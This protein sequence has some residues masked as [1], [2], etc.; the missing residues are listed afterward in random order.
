M[1]DGV[2][3]VLVIGTTPDMGRVIARAGWRRCK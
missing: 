3:T 1:N 2:E